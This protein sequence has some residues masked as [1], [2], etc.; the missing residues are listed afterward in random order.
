MFIVEPLPTKF[1]A[2][3]DDVAPVVY[4]LT[5]NSLLPLPGWLSIFRTA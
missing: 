4:T 1:T 3:F 2:L 5:G